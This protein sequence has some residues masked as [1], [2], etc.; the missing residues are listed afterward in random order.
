VFYLEGY[1]IIELDLS[2]TGS[3]NENFYY[4]TVIVFDNYEIAPHAAKNGTLVL[5]APFATFDINLLRDT[6]GDTDIRCPSG[7]RAHQHQAKHQ[8]LHLASFR[9]T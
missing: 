7:C 5:E 2:S 9:K 1:R 3:L 6:L 8:V 4:L